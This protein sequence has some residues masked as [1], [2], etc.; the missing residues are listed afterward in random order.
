MLISI[1]IYCFCPQ[2]KH[3]KLIEI[4]KKCI[5]NAL[6]CFTGFFST[7]Y[8]QNLYLSHNFWNL[9]LKHQNH[10]PNLQNRR[11]IP[12][13]S[14][15]INLPGA[16][17]IERHNIKYVPISLQCL[18]EMNTRGSKTQMPCIPF[19]TNVPCW[20]ILGL[21]CLFAKHKTQFSMY[22]TK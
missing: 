3:L 12:T 1:R 8:T 14:H 2:Y 7:A 10:T 9:T 20:L 18:K 21:L 5:K 17:F 4:L 19:H 22:H 13:W 11:L 16:L 6:L 15:G